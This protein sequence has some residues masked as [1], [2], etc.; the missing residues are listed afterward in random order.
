MEPGSNFN[1]NDT[2]II[3]DRRDY[4]LAFITAQSNILNAEVI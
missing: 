3:L 4:E 1:R 2:L